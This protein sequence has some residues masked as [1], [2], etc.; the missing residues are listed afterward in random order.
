MV[1]NFLSL[2][3]GSRGVCEDLATRLNTLGWTTIQTSSRAQ[4]LARLCDMT[5]TAWSNRRDYSVAQIDVYSGPAFFWAESVCAVLRLAG[6]PYVLTL[7]GGNLPTFARKWPNRVARL[8]N[9]AAAVT[10][11]SGFLQTSLALYCSRIRVLPNPLDVSNYSFRRR[12]VARPNLVW[13]R[14]FHRIYNP[15]LAA[16]V[17]A[18]LRPDYPD[19]RLTM[20]G[21]DK[22]DGSFQATRHHAAELGVAD[23]IAFTGGL[24]KCE[25]PAR[26]Q[27][28]DIFINTTNIDNTPVSVMEALACGLCVV[29]TDAG[30][31]RHL[32]ASGREALLVPCGDA[33]AMAAAVRGMLTNPDLASALSWR[34]RQKALEWDWSVVLPQWEELLESVAMCRGKDC[35][36]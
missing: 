12:A 10:A 17:I 15:L 2:L 28:A 11:P 36:A 23:C 22:G 3:G 19:I 16:D 14:A 7:H 24:P 30:G 26:L 21:P 9:S 1:G 33:Q 6:R 27:D 18:L 5:Y 8:L 4:R 25:L 29:S 31:V 34:G 32:V 20:I 13:V 35:C